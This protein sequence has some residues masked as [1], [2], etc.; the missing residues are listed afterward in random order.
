MGPLSLDVDFGD[1]PMARRRNTGTLRGNGCHVGSW[2]PTDE[3]PLVEIAGSK[4]IAVCIS[5]RQWHV[6]YPHTLFNFLNV[7]C[8]CVF[9][10]IHSLFLK[11]SEQTQT[12]RYLIFMAQQHNEHYIDVDA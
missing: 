11:R 5:F 3:V 12:M 1:L 4:V 9:S 2:A 6:F 7:C 8:F 10:A